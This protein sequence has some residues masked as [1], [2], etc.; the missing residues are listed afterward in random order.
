MVDFYLKGQI[1][2]ADDCAYGG[3]RKGTF[4]EVRLYA[5]AIAYC[6][7]MQYLY[8]ICPWEK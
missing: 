6:P 3:A 5:C 4:V 2:C 8:Q 1:I 7:R